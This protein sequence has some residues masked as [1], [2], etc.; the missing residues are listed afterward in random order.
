MK[1]QSEILSAFGLPEE[2][3]VRPFGN[4]LINDTYLVCDASDRPSYILQRINTTIFTDPAALQENIVLTTRHI[5]SKLTE[6]GVKDINRRVL[7]FIPRPGNNLTYFTDTDGSTWRISEYIADST[8]H[9]SVTPESSYLAGKAFGEFQSMLADMP[10][11]L[12]ETIPGFHDMELRLRQFRE[13]VASDPRGRVAEVSDLIEEIERRADDM[14]VAERLGRDGKLPKRVCHCDTKVNNMLFDSQSGDFLCVID[15]DTVMPSYVFSDYG[16]F[17][18]TA[19]NTAPEDE[20]DTNRIAFD[21]DIFRA[22][23]RGYLESAKFLNETEKAYLP[24]AVTLFPFMQGVRFL[25]DY[26]NGDT[27]Y[28][29]SYPTHNL[30]RARA[31]FALFHK[32]ESAVPMMADFIASL[33]E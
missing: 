2:C 7:H 29:I 22:F 31:Q 15:L 14:C 21:M 8:S 26:I 28:R 13:A 4:G 20:P 11:S 9:E 12:T 10:D 24:F 33:S 3:S 1:N 27:Y 25:T 5:E 17:L 16:D 30:V 23:T 18:R 19:A 6:K 32:A